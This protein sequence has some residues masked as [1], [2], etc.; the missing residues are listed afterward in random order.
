ME[1]PIDSKLVELLRSKV[2]LAK[3]ATDKTF[4]CFS[5]MK[6]VLKSIEKQFEET[7]SNKD[8]RIKVSYTDKGLFEMELKV[9]DDILIFIMHTNALVF[10]TNHPMYKTGYVSLDQTRATCGM[11]SVYNFLSDSFKFDRRN[12]T[13]VLVAR[14]FINRENHFF[15]EGK[16]QLGILYNDFANNA[17]DSVKL[18]SFIESVIQYSLDID[19]TVPSFDAMKEIS[20]HDAIQY[21]LHSAVAS[22]KSL[23]FDFQNRQ[24]RAIE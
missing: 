15:A 12:D 2:S 14:V 24:K 8:Q 13:G 22:A 19:V 9:G 18:Q 16:K 7:L 10:E 23:G 5:L 1:K 3:D 4:E 20:V 11:I 6:A 17:A 21:S